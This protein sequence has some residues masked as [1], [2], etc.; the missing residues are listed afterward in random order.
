ML[1]SSPPPVPLASSWHD[2]PEQP[3]F[4]PRPCFLASRACR[5]LQPQSLR[6]PDRCLAAPVVRVP[7]CAP[8]ILCRSFPQETGDRKGFAGIA[9]DLSRS[10]EHTS[11]LQSHL[12]LVCR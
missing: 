6:F 12:N 7:A 4:L 11:E 8:G 1:I 10:E 2:L 9:A 5:R 3:V